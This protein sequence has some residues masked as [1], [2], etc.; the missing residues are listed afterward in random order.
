MIYLGSGEETMGAEAG[1]GRDRR[2]RPSNGR[3]TMTDVARLAGVSQSSVSLVLNNMSG[4]RISEAT[5]QKVL[6]AARTIGYRLPGRRS[7][8]GET[9]GRIIALVLD[10]IS[11]SPH[12]VV[13]VDGARD[14]AWEAGHLVAVHVTR[15]DPDLEAAT[16]RAIL[17]DGALLGIVYAT[18][19]T[20]KVTPPPE[21]ANVPA[22]LLNCYTADKA[23]PSVIPSEVAGGF[24]ATEHLLRH[25]HRRIGFI[26]GEPW[27]DAS[28]DRLKGYRHALASADIAFD[29]DLVRNGDWLPDA[30]YRRTYELLRLPNPPSA[31]FCA[32]DLMAVGALEALAELGLRVPGDISVMGY[33]DQEMARYTRPP[34]STCLLPNYEMGRFAAETLIALA[35]GQTAGRPVQLKMEGPLVPRDS[36]GR[37]NPELKR[38]V[39]QVSDRIV[40][41]PTSQPIHRAFSW[42]SLIKAPADP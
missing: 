17:A 6:S 7:D 15:A 21:L 14:A 20:R 35:Q 13:S 10:E 32:N 24:A 12:P 36:V 9:Q 40:T 42:G 4:A 34:L 41:G 23:L 11:T 30:G 39:A 5:R 22:V 2:G 26:N 33:D 37:L 28:R 1:S 18:I 25:G 8:P 19:F 29:A 3:P 38:S 31:L 16:L 27:M